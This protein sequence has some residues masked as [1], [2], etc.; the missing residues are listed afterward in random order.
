VNAV[1]PSFIQTPMTEKELAD[2]LRREEN[3]SRVPMG[4]LGVPQ[5]VVGAV[6]YLASDAASLVTG[7]TLAVDG[8][9]TA[10]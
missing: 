2:P 7:H 1:A 3:L 8:G 10:G 4:R 9:Y 5:D 6:V